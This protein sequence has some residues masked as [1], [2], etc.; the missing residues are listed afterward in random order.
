MKSVFFT[1]WPWHIPNTF[2]MIEELSIGKSFIRHVFENE[3]KL[4]GYCLTICNI[5]SFKH[6]FI[7]NSTTF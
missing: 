2:R 3:G 4:C 6:H 7:C 1:N 5:N